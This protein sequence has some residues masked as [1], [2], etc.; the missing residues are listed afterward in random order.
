M[1]EMLRSRKPLIPDEILFVVDS[2]TGQDAVNTAKEFNDVSTLT[3]LFLPSWMVI[4]VVVL[5]FLSVRL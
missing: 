4:P 5:H 1:N 2:M 3:V